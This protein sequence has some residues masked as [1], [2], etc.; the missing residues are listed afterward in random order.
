MKIDPAVREQTVRVAAGTA[1]LTVLMIAFFLILGKFDYTVLLGAL[2][3][4]TTAVGNFF[5]MA[6]TVQHL[7]DSMPVL[8]KEEEKSEPEGSEGTGDALEADRAEKPLSPEARQAGQK[9]QIS[10]VLRLI[11]V[12]LVAVIALKVPVF[13]AWAAL[14]PLLFPNIVIALLRGR[15]GRG[16]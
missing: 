5:L 11:L 16:A 15:I 12:A 3:G 6:L 10:F 9:M 2:L 8:P 7:T 14:I 4:C 13:N 1:I